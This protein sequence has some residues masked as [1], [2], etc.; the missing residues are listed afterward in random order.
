MVDIVYVAEKSNLEL[1]TYG[2]GAHADYG[3]LTLLATDDVSGLQVPIN[4]PIQSTLYK[5]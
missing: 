4:C 2:C 5:C 3:M 1:R